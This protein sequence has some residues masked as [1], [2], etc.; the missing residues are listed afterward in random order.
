MRTV[1]LDIASATNF[2]N[3]VQLAFIEYLLYDFNYKVKSL[4]YY[5]CMMIGIAAFFC[6]SQENISII[7]SLQHFILHWWPRA[8]AGYFSLL[9]LR[10]L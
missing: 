10:G 1:T 9:I 6:S 7:S 5:R 4:F 8:I 3:H 2:G